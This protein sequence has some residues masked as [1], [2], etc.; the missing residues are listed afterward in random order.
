MRGLRHAATLTVLAILTSDGHAPPALAVP[1]Q[2]PASVP[3]LAPPSGNVVT[4]SNEAQ[5]QTAVA[6]LTSGQTIVISPGIYRLTQTLRVGGRRLTDVALRGATNRRDDV[7][8]V[9]P[10]M[11]NRDFGPTPYGIWTGDGVDRL[12]IANMTIRD[13]YVHPVIFNAGTQSPHLYNV[14]LID[15]GEQLLKSNPDPHGGGVNDAIVEH[16]L[17]AFSS[18]SRD[19]YTNAIDVHAGTNWTIRYNWFVNIRAPRGQLAGPAILMWRGSSGTTVDGNRFVNCQREISF[20][21]EPPRSAADERPGGVIK[22]NMIA[23]D[24]SVQGDAAILVGTPATE[25]LHNTILIAGTYS[26]AVEY[27]FA[28]TTNVAIAN[29]LTDRS[30]VARDGARAAVHHNVTSA[31]R[32][33]FVN[34]ARGDLHLRSDARIARAA[35]EWSKDASVDVDGDPRPVGAAP[36]VGADQISE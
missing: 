13:F 14:A 10:G 25:V 32:R 16:S 36:D 17:F 9:G 28:G 19:D 5:L 7:Q 20:G 6:R 23:R 8:L 33:M 4:V 35:G 31:E 34:A 27:R 3:S 22:N 2:V 12:L 11:T 15:G 26:H 30:I 1:A 29:N 21:L 24:P 18:S